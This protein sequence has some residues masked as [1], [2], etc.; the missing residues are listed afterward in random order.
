MRYL[1]LAISRH[2]LRRSRRDDEHVPRGEEE[3]RVVKLVH[4]S[5]S[6]IW[7]CFGSGRPR[8]PVF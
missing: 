5:Q 6:V 8:C 2:G 4:M 3:S 1:K 7:L